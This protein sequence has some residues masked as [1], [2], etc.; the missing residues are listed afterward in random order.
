[1]CA[2]SL[3]LEYTEPGKL[4]GYHMYIVVSSWLGFILQCF[5][6]LFVK[7]RLNRGA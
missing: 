6:C 5:L 3:I 4:C 2:L 7:D 1:M